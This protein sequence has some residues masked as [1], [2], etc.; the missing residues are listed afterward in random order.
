MKIDNKSNEY[1]CINS[2][3]GGDRIF[4]KH[5]T[6]RIYTKGWHDKAFFS[7]ILFLDLWV[8]QRT[9]ITW[10]KPQADSRQCASRTQI[11][12]LISIHAF[13]TSAHMYNKKRV[14]CIVALVIGGG[15]SHETHTHT[16]NCISHRGTLRWKKSHLIINYHFTHLKSRVEHPPPSVLQK[17]IMMKKKKKKKKKKERG[18]RRKNIPIPS[19]SF[20]FFSFSFWV[21]ALCPCKHPTSNFIPLNSV[22]VCVCVH[23]SSHPIPKS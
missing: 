10:E 20:L 11:L 1:A 17:Y 19:H 16:H 4:N 22:C 8:R 13:K 12:I 18:T 5:G 15:P 6:S 3:G 21:R 7:Y 14:R 9:R 2:Q 23:I